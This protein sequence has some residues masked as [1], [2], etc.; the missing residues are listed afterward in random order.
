MINLFIINFVIKF[1]QS[2]NREN[3]QINCKFKNSFN[4]QIENLLN[5][6]FCLFN[7]FLFKQYFLIK[8]FVILKNFLRGF[9]ILHLL[10]ILGILFA[11]VFYFGFGFLEY[12]SGK[13]AEFSFL[14]QRFGNK[15][16]FHQ[17]ISNFKQSLKEIK[18]MLN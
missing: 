5:L 16:L 14:I 4:N 12:F 2:F 11:K 15:K 13:L 9:L 7:F 18:K 6:S 10:I 3:Q 8:F 1:V 17:N